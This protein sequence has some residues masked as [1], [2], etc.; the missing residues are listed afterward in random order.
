M[1]GLDSWVTQSV[2]HD[3]IICYNNFLA[4][5]ILIE[6]VKSEIYSKCC[7]IFWAHEKLKS[8]NAPV[9]PCVLQCLNY[10]YYLILMLCSS[11]SSWSCNNCFY[12]RCTPQPN[13]SRIKTW[14][15]FFNTSWNNRS[16][17]VR[18]RHM[19]RPFN[20]DFCSFYL[21]KE[22]GLNWRDILNIPYERF[23][24][25]CLVKSWRIHQTKISNCNKGIAFKNN[26][27]PKL[28]WIMAI[29]SN[30]K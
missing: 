19:A 13:A 27:I 21:S 25:I 9:T 8:W 16:R 11:K 10:L 18:D 12:W 26:C 7:R 1:H 2:T 24:W 28:F 14:S 30:T 5:L 17:H 29:I 23:L 3:G 15:Q 20:F 4:G 22:Y 6:I